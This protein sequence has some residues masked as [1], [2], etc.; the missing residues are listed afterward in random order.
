[1]TQPIKCDCYSDI[2]GKMEFCPLHRAAPDLLIALEVLCL[3]SE[4]IKLSR[5]IETL[6]AL[7]G[8]T[9]D[10]HAAIAKAKEAI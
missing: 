7:G 4:S 5:S 6:M 10:A 3:A 2:D 8:A 1:M 9:N